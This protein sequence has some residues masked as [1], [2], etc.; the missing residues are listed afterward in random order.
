MDKN[1]DR[2]IRIEAL[3]IAAKVWGELSGPNDQKANNLIRLAD[4]LVVYLNTGT[5]ASDAERGAQESD[6]ALAKFAEA[7][8][9]TL[10]M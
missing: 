3:K 2:E 8:V 5:N 9:P 7:I 4:I 1:K 10:N 6:A